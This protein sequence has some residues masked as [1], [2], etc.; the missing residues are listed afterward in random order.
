MHSSQIRKHVE[1]DIRLENLDALHPHEK[2]DPKAV[3]QLA[4]EIEADGLQK[5]PIIVE[6]DSRVVLDGMHRLAAL[7]KLACTSILCYL[8]PYKDALVDRWCRL[9][10]SNQTI[11]L[12][13]LIESMQRLDK[14]DIEYINDPHEAAQFVN[15]SKA[16]GALITKEKSILINNKYPIKDLVEIYNYLMFVAVLFR[17]HFNINARYSSKIEIERKDVVGVLVPPIVNKKDVIKAAKSNVLFPLKSTRHILKIRPLSIDLP[18]SFLQEEN[19]EGNNEKLKS[20]LHQKKINYLPRGTKIRGR[21]Y[22]EAILQYEQL[23]Q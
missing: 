18:L 11:P 23:N 15:E 17:F 20:F 14:F 6:K 2:T 5:D 4:Q 3:N 16:A 13:Q 12:I 22:E 10:I 7:K 1:S 21:T 8:V 19:I 9:L